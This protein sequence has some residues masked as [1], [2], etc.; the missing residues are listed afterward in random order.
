MTRTSGSIGGA[1]SVAALARIGVALPSVEAASPAALLAWSAARGR[2]RSG[3]ADAARIA[4][5]GDS[6]TMGA[7]AGAGTGPGPGTAG[8]FARA[9]PARVS[10][11]LA[12]GGLPIRADAF[13]GC[14]GLA[15]IADVLIYD[16]R[17]SGFSGWGGGGNSLGGA[18]MSTNN[19]NPAQF[20]SAGPVDRCSVFIRNGSDRPA[21]SVRKGGESV[22]LTPSGPVGGFARLEVTFQ[23]RDANP[24][25]VVRTGTTGN[26]QLVGLVAWD[27]ARPGI[28]I[29][30]FGVFGVTSTFQAD[31][32]GPWSPAAALAT[33]AP[34]L[35]IVNLG[36]NDLA[37]KQPMANWLTNIRTIARQARLTGSV[38]LAW[39]AVGGTS[40]TGG[41][42]AERAQWRTALRALAFE[43][44]ALF[45]DEEALL[46]GR[47]V[48]QASGAF[49]DSLHESPWAYD[50]QAAAIARAIL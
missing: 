1:V 45:V 42:D 14:A 24:I 8:A 37:Q 38:I 46:G 34:H 10:A 44:D 47:A 16:P 19:S 12:A 31:T 40:P 13:F 11:L 35:T 3:M 36:T 30:N 4:F 15:S 20:Q 39:P 17:R 23:A 25:M 48:A 49:T 33:Y 6:K 32:T 5:V 7:G 27:S 41:G 22:P 50:V 2:L 21:F 29:V 9:R 43:I 18:A 28:E 26:L